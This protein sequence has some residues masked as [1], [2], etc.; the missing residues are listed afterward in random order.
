[1]IRT[2]IKDE[3]YLITDEHDGSWCLLRPYTTQNDDFANALVFGLTFSNMNH[4]W[5]KSCMEFLR[6]DGQ[7]TYPYLRGKRVSVHGREVRLATDLEK[8]ILDRVAQIGALTD[9]EIRELK[10]DLVL[11]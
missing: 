8:A 11:E 10:I 7:N 4:I 1:M 3:T 5:R 2:F 9:E 6:E